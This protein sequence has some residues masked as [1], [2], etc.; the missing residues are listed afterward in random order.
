MK[1]SFTCAASKPRRGAIVQVMNQL[2]H[3]PAQIAMVGD[4]VLTDVLVGNRLGLYTVLV[5]PPQ[6]DG[7]PCSNDRVQQF[8]RRLARWLGAGGR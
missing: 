7:S 5:R 3:P 6:L 8:E 2:S 4:R 1:V